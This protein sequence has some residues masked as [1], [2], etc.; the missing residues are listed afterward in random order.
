M[1]LSAR[2]N[3]ILSIIIDQ[4]I[5]TGEPVGSKTVA[6]LLNN[7]VSSATIRNEMAELCDLG[8]LEQPHTSSGR[9][10]SQ[11]GYRYYVDRLMGRYELANDEMSRIERQLEGASS[12]PE[13]LLIK[14]SAILA[15]L[16]GCAAI[17]TTPKD[18]HT[19]IK[20]VELVPTSNR[21]MMVV[22]VTSSG[23]LKSKVCRMDVPITLEL[24]ELFYNIAA[25]NF[26]GVKVSD[27][28]A[29]MLQNIAASL[30]DKAFDMLSLVN[31]VADLA[32]SCTN[33]ELLLE[34]EVN[35][36]THK[37]LE[38]NA[39]V[40]MSFLQDGGLLSKL[41]TERSPQL[42][43]TIGSENVFKEL[44]NSSMILSGYSVMGQNAGSVG[45]IGPTRI[46]YARLIP[47]IRFL[48]SLVGRLLTEVSET[49]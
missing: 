18:E 19:V 5:L 9:I 48:S 22:L 47:S 27:I 39:L 40:L 49:E 15:E 35:L 46:D 16:T 12:E 3:K 24:I 30:G 21:S 33:S 20:K 6:A 42:S 1:N 34:G 13:A 36:L 26:I 17:S 4:Y 10:P 41:L 29:P 44:E 28:Y 14:A 2:K 32:Q 38:A 25:V 11:K 8:Y 7:A 23:M 31:A 45:I 37:E 43:V